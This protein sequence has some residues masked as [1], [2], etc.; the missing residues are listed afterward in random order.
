MPLLPFLSCLVYAL[1]LIIAAVLCRRRMLAR[2]MKALYI[3]YAP[4]PSSVKP[5]SEKSEVDRQLLPSPPPCPCIVSFHSAYVN[6][7]ENELT[8][9]MGEWRGCIGVGGDWCTLISHPHRVHGWRHSGG[10]H[11]WDGDTIRSGWVGAMHACNRYCP[12]LL[13]I[14]SVLLPRSSAVLANIAWRTLH[15]LAFVHAHGLLHRDIKPGMSIFKG[16]ISSMSSFP[17]R[18]SD[19]PFY[20]A[21]NLLINHL[22][23]LKISDFGI[24]RDMTVPSLSAQHCRAADAAV[25]L[26]TGPSAT[27]QSG[28]NAEFS[29]LLADT[30]VGTQQYMSPECLAGRQYSY[31]ADV[32]SAGLCVLAVALGRY[33]LNPTAGKG[34]Y[35]L[36][37]RA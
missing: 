26:Q 13:W 33:P 30:F 32:W 6:A 21:G 35:P 34:R 37:F 11:R 20:A 36:S 23:E 28:D 8:F 29:E 18:L 24:S 25:D 10:A 3:N 9:V 31:S 27:I 22:G 14:L 5:T 2:E 4:F 19:L 12:A 16:G 17:A 15:G 7:A 1:F